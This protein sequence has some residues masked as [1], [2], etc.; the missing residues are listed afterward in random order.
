MNQDE[1]EAEA[2]NKD[3]DSVKSMQRRVEILVNFFT[4][5]FYSQISRSLF[6]RHKLVFT[7]ILTAK[8]KQFSGLISHM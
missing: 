5:H 3:S 8:L 1:I 7:F 4:F 2:P 6:Q